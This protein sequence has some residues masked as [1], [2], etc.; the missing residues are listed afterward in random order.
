M[1]GLWFVLLAGCVD[2]AAG[3]GAGPG[4]ATSQASQPI[5]GG[6]ESPSVYPATGAITAASRL[7]C[8]GTLIAPDVV[9][10]AAHCLEPAIFGYLGFTLDTDFNDG[11]GE[12]VKAL[13]THQHPDYYSGNVFELG[14]RNDVGVMILERP[15]EVP[16]YELFD[17]PTEPSPDA[18]LSMCGYGREFW[19]SRSG[20][21][22]MTADV[23]VASVSDLEFSTSEMG[24]QPCSGDSGGPLFRESPGEHALVGLVSR[25][26]GITTMCDTGAIITRTAPYAAWIAE[27]SAD[28]S[29]GCA[30]GLCLP[31]AVLAPLWPRRRRRPR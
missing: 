8:T 24:P 1:R 20:G 11:A 17:I 27:A 12:I 4:A 23:T 30:G 15:I 29:I 3:P 14:A 7:R 21:I 13:V 6:T 10:T 28:R 9:L 2:P 22:K 19:A 16:G 26:F 18:T 31:L 25:A 5:I